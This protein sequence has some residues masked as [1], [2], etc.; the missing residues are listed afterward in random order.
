MSSPMRVCSSEAKVPGF[1]F[2]F[3]FGQR[4][5]RRSNACIAVITQPFECIIGDPMGLVLP[6]SV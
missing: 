5:A 1:I 4:R 2:Y 3:C 6:A